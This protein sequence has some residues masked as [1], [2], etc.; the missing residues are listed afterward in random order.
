MGSGA[1]HPAAAATSTTAAAIN[2]LA[3]EA[4]KLVVDNGVE[5]AE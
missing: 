1:R 3:N 2:E 4:E 5:V